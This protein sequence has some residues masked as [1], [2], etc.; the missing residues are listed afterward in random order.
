M[1]PSTAHSGDMTQDSLHLL[2]N[3]VIGQLL[4]LK[5]ESSIRT[6]TKRVETT[7][8]WDKSNTINDTSI[9]DWFI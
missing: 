5:T 1:L 3:S 7:V 4:L 8:N 9:E 6:L 2:R